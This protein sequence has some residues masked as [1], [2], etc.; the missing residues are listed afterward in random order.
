MSAATRKLLR[1]KPGRKANK[2]GEQKAENRKQTPPAPLSMA[3]RS[4][5]FER[6]GDAARSLYVE[7]GKSCREINAT[8]PV[9]TA[10]I[11]IWCGRG[12]WEAQRR[13]RV[14]GPQ[15]HV[16][17]VEA[18]LAALVKEAMI[19]VRK[20][21]RPPKGT[22]DEIAKYAAALKSLR[23]DSY[24]EGHMMTVLNDLANYLEGKDEVTRQGLANHIG[25]FVGWELGRSNS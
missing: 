23:G 14:A 6:Y 12:G 7:Q 18:M 5:K 21:K 10:R 11:Q 1:E 17:D 24:F 8:M 9:S 22:A 15:A 3:R 25:G 2:S 16:S 4:P 20:G 19:Y 13:M